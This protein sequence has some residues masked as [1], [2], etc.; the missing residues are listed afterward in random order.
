MRRSSADGIIANPPSYG[1][2]HCA[3]ALHIPLHMIFTMPWTPTSAPIRTRSHASTRARIGPCSNW[4]SYGVVDVL[5]WVGVADRGQPLPRERRS[6]CRTDRAST[7]A[8]RRS[9]R[10]RGAVHL[11]VSRPASSQSPPDWGSHI[12]VANFIFFDQADGYD[13]AARLAP[14]FLA[15]GDAPIYVGFGSCVVE[16]PVGHEPHDSSPR[17]RRRR[18][19]ASC[20]ADAGTSA[21]T[22]RPPM[23][24]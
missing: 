15:A 18:F 17:W 19:V 22:R 10:Q 14:R 1:H 24:I 11:S 8:R 16:D 7:M 21:A 9:D 2:F 4:F 23:C 3:E 12:D 6:G 5:M 20:R 13:A